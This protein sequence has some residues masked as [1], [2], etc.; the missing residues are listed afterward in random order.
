M[1]LVFPICQLTPQEVKNTKVKKNTYKKLTLEDYYKIEDS[2]SSLE[3]LR[4]Q[5]WRDFLGK[6][7]IF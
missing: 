4:H 7:K 3:R 2:V 5:Q 6:Y 1:S